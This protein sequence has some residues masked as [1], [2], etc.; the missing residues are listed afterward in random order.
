MTTAR[1]YAEIT[2]SGAPRELGRQLGEAAGEWIREFCAIALE[3]VNVTVAVSRQSACRV[4]AASIPYAERYSPDLVEEL[5][6]TAEA[7]RVTLEDLMLLQVRNQLKPDAAGGC[8]SFSL[9]GSA[10]VG[11]IAAQNWDNDPELDRFTIV[12]TRRPLGKPAFTTVTQAGLIAYIGFSEA[13]MGVCLN[14]LPAPSRTRG[15]PHYFTVREI[16]E[17]RTLDAAVHAV[18]RAERAIPANIMLTTPQGPADLEVTIDDVHV[19]TDPRCVTHANHCKHP[20]LA[21]INGEFSELIQSHARQRRIDELLAA[22][23]TSSEPVA[24]L[25]TIL[26]DHHA[27]PRSICRHANTD[28][29]TGFWQTVFSAII[30]PEAGRMHL[31]RGTPCDRAYE[32]YALGT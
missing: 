19:L 31:T 32:V 15:V 11:R 26:R 9:A 23:D 7:A 12:L 4:A 2:V 18:R 30:E 8:T 27:H 16:Y 20:D 22:V 6:G 24:A 17:A 14:S 10:R 3:R 21:Q 28:P 13:G 29:G 25:Q 5:R 1:R